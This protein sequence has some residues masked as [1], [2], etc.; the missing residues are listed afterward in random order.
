[1]YSLVRTQITREKMRLENRN[2]LCI[3]AQRAFG[4]PFIV[5]TLL[6]TN[7]VPGIVLKAFHH[8]GCYVKQSLRSKSADKETS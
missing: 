6:N 7:Y 4:H 3:S 2:R 1:M 8:S 5:I